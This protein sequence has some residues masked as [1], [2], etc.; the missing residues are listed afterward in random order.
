MERSLHKRAALVVMAVLAMAGAWAFAQPGRAEARA[1]LLA[2]SPRIDTVRALVPERGRHAGRLVV[3]VRVLHARGTRRAL[4]RERPETFHRARIAIRVG[5]ARRVAIEHLDLGRRRLAHGYHFRLRRSA[6]RAAQAGGGGRVPVSVSVAQTV[7]LDSDG[8]SEDRARAAATRQVALARPATSIEPRDGDFVNGA[9]DRLQVAGGKVVSYFFF[10]GTGSPCGVGPS[11]NVSAPID[12]QTGNFSFNDTLS[13]VIS[14]PVT[15]TA[16][17]TFTD[18]Q[19]MSLNADVNQ[20]SCT[21]QVTPNTFFW[22]Q[23]G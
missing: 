6:V 22:S 15:T 19:S 1:N 21:Y 5:K 23:Y 7:D 8:G 3:W 18:A 14:P 2:G 11:D 13:A 4:A 12:P 17:G 20:G 9:S 16:Q 10:S